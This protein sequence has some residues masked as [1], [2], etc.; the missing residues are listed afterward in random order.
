MSV[1][2]AVIG[3]GWADTV[4]IPAFQAGGLE[5]VGVA[6]RNPDKAAQVAKRHHIPMSTG[7]W[8][9]LLELDCDLIS[10][11]SPPMLHKEQA[12]AVLEAGKHLICEKPLALNRAEAEAMCEVAAQ[13]PQQLALVDHELR[14]VPARRKAKELLAGGA[15]GRIFTVTVRIT[16]SFRAQPDKPWSWWSDAS[17]G[18]GVLGAIGSHALDGLRYLLPEL[19]DTIEI[20]GATLGRAYAQRP[21]ADGG[22]RSVSSDDIVSLTFCMGDVV[23]TM[24][25]HAV[26]LDEPVDLLTIRGEDGTLVLDKS[27][28]LYLGKGDG[29]LKEYVTHLPGIVPNRFRSNPF[30][31]GSVLLAEALADALHPEHTKLEQLQS[32]ATLHDGL[33][34][35][36]L[37]DR[38]KVLA[39][40]P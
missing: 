23:G 37:I 9:E 20:Q 24:L 35:Q 39:N 31:A 11:T 27:L 5:V 25:V 7:D 21:D 4:Q 2:V 19:A 17:L 13:H 15:V 38:T 32:L 26:G 12:I 22:M 18:G 8:R 14:L 40:W 6:G 34:V 10:V 28:K 30:A 16:S 29:Q 3:T 33:A 1:K 36:T